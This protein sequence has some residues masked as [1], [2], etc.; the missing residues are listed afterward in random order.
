MINS[1][2]YYKKLNTIENKIKDIDE[3]II[4]IDNKKKLLVSSRKKLIQELNFLKASNVLIE[5][6]LALSEIMGEENFNIIKNQL[7]NKSS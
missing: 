1:K 7:E 5:N 6:K 3:K 2:Y 4:K